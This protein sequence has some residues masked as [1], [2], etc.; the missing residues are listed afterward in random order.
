MDS[1]R[2]IRGGG[3]DEE[4]LVIGCVAKKKGK[5]EPNRIFFHHTSFCNMTM[6]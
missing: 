6:T 3:S 2:G 1:E 5:G 4:V